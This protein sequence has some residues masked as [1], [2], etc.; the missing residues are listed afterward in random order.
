MS[1]TV[2]NREALFKYYPMTRGII[3]T[4]N[5]RLDANGNS[6]RAR[7][8]RGEYLAWRND[9]FTIRGKKEARAFIAWHSSDGAP[10]NVNLKRL[11]ACTVISPAGPFKNAY[12][13]PTDALRYAET[14]DRANQKFH[15]DV[16]TADPELYA[17]WI[18]FHTEMR[19]LLSV[20]RAEFLANTIDQHEYLTAADRKVHKKNGAAALT[21]RLLEAISDEH[22]RSQ[23]ECRFW[24]MKHALLQRRYS[25][26]PM[27]KI[28]DA[29]ADLLANESFDPSNKIES[30]LASA[31][32]YWSINLLKIAL[33]R[34]GAS[35][36]P[37][38]YGRIVGGGTASAE[39]TFFGLHMRTDGQHSVMG[40]CSGVA[41][42]TNG[43]PRAQSMAGVNML[44]VLLMSETS[45]AAPPAKKL[46]VEE[47]AA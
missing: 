45:D 22:N 31:D 38:E 33:A 41:L 18:D 8:K 28:C 26:G 44:D 47:V 3:D 24:S 13:T 27:K 21:E 10:L 19:N 23:H 1:T 30:F 20:K 5:D 34:P 42:L 9:T 6:W 39:L 2:D 35:V 25:D 40:S 36:G 11:P 32:D 17:D 46:R 7:K 15:F 16:E 43:E 29:D 4:F 12:L 37:H 14:A